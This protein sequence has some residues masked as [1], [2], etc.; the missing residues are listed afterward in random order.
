MKPSGL[1]RLFKPQSIAVIGAST[2]PQK[3]G[4]VVIRHLLAG[5]FKG[6]ILPVSPHNRAIAGVL[7]YPDISCLPL[8]PDLAIICT[9]RE[10]VLPLIE[11]LGKK[12]TGAAIIL[13]ADFSM[14]ERARLQQLSRQYDI[15]LLGPNS[16]GMLLPG[17]GINASF[18]PIAAK[19][20]QVA[21]L[22]QSAAVST[23]ILDWAKQHELGFSAF[24]SLGDHCDIDFGQLLDQL[25][26]DGTTRAILLYMDKLHDARHFLS[27]ARAASRNKPILVL[28]SGRHDPANGLDNVYDAAIR[29]AGMLRVRDTHELFAAVETL[30]H[31]LTLKGERLAI[32]S[33]GRGLANMAI[34]V[35]LE[36]GGKLAMPPRDIGSD[37]DIATYRQALETLLQGDEADAILLIHAPS[38]TARGAELARNLIDYVKQHPRA[39]R[40]NILTN[41]AGEYSAQEGRRLFSEAGFPTY[42]TPESAVAAF[43][44]MVE[45]RRNQKQLMET[46]ASLQGDKLNVELCQQLIRQALERK[47]LTLDT[48]LVHPILQ[49]AGLSTLPTWIV[50]DAIEATLT[51]EQIGYPVAVKLRSPDIAHKSAVHGVM[52]NLR[53]SAEVAQAADAILDRVRQHDAGARI[54]GLLVQRMARRSGGLELRIRLQQDPVFGP[55]ILLGESGAEPQE[56]VAA[57]PPLNQALARYQ[58][59]GALKSRKIREQ[60]TPERLDID[61]LGQ[62]L[63]QLSELLLAFPEI[64]ELDLHPLQA[65]GAEMVI[66]DASLTL[67]PVVQGRN[68]LAIRPYPTE[69][70]E[71]AWLKDQSHVLLRPIRPEDEP[72]HKQFVLKVSDE[73]RYKRFFADVGELGHEELARMT[74]I[75]YD[76]EM[77]FVAVGQDGAFSQ[78]ILGVVRAI[79]NPDLSDAEFAI[80][81]RSDLKGLGL[82][83]LMME[84]IARYARERGIGQLSGMTMPSNRGMIN[85][86]KRL[87]FKIDIQLEDGVVNMELPCANQGQ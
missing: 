4:H 43:M 58:I 7:A 71:G 48:H 15:R 3:A 13:A 79:S 10:R 11:E 69:L 36:R 35:L 54:E 57:L 51:A 87:G 34:D 18:S 27:A 19:P 8:S 45:Y 26:R 86:A 74:Q 62:V 59:I 23:T 83:K 77:A 75:D 68:T 20:G 2:D 31:S 14:Q 70:E 56:M 50:S 81:V 42:R 39:R 47:Q 72:A 21:F 73:D 37:A 44:H 49:A 85:L 22:S 16:M 6:P 9:K 30:S 32:I 41:W 52:L 82:G 66:L 80:L 40:F 46:P 33:N 1:D 55:V 53:T 38:L 25:S 29:R 61:A 76:R 12:G 17:Q 5:Q 65:C 64:Q 60:A 28:K 24:I 67:M 78:Q 84:K 63:C